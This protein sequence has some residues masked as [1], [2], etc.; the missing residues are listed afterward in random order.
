VFPDR[1]TTSAQRLQTDVLALVGQLN[2]GATA[3]LTTGV[4][5][6]SG[7]NKIRHGLPNAPRAVSLSPRS[8]VAWWT[9]TA[10][11]SE[12][13]YITTAGVLTADVVVW[14]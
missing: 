11:D 7:L 10:P 4:V 6:A 1:P 14:I 13:L 9:A 3:V 5:L 8:N 12:F 2:D